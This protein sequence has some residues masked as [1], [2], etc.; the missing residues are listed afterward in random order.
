LEKTFSL[1]AT[2]GHFPVYTNIFSDIIFI[3]LVTEYY[4][5][6]AESLYSYSND[7]QYCKNI[8]QSRAQIYTN[9]N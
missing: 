8:F 6:F 5:P 9:N 1:A 4:N 3:N 7:H 2:S